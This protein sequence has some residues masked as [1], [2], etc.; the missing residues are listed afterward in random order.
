MA[1][2][3][4]EED[5]ADVVYSAKLLLDQCEDIV[6]AEAA[7]STMSTE[8]LRAIEKELRVA[9][10][11]DGDLVRELAQLYVEIVHRAGFQMSTRGLDHA[12]VAG[13][14][15]GVLR[16]FLDGAYT[17]YSRTLGGQF[18]F[19]HVRETPER[20][21]VYEVST[22]LGTQPRRFRITVSAV[23]IR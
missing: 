6:D 19:T 8:V 22:A 3:A 9:P 16:E 4:A 2:H 21:D 23:E 5:F 12:T 1:K 14:A 17:D 7:L 20:A 15:A 18:R 13:M 10:S 11:D